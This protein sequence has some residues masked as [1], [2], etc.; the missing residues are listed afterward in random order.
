MQ[1]PYVADVLAI[2]GSKHLKKIVYSVCECFWSICEKRS[3][4]LLKEDQSVWKSPAHWNR[5]P[6]NIQLES[7]SGLLTFQLIG[8]ICV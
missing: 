7:T 6:V 1:V 5:E 3:L 8:V 4:E 2:H